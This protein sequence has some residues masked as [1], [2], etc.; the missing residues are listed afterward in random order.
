MV[1]ATSRTAYVAPESINAAADIFNSEED[2]AYLAGGTDLIPLVKYGLNRAAC[3]ID[4]EKIDAL[5]KISET[6][7]GVFIGSMSTLS[8]LIKNSLINKRLSPVAYAARCVASPQIRN[9]G[10]AGG[11][12][13]QGKRCFYFN[14]SDYWKE[15][16]SPCYKRDGDV[17]YQILKA[18][19]CQAI[20]YSDLAPILL[21]YNA[22]AQIYDG[23][24]YKVLPLEDII[25]THTRDREK[26]FLLTGFIVPSSDNNTIGKFLK[27]SV[28]GSIDFALSNVG[29]CFSAGNR[30]DEKPNIRIFAGAV[31]AEPLRLHRTEEILLESLNNADLKKQDI[32]HTG[33]KELESRCSLIR[34]T[35]V[36]VRAKKNSLLIIAEALRDFLPFLRT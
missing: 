14:Q 15:S 2:A 22:E 19:T 6:A 16:V 17:C 9:M 5:K 20:Y 8:D 1:M 33:I 18:K 31:S 23:K 26:K 21:A 32:I 4:L 3:M 7:E 34:E 12:V 25:Y 10:T 13:L 27:Y 28:R 29:I 24:T 30:K 11:N 36:S 35:T